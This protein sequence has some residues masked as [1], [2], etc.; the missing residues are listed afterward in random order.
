MLMKISCLIIETWLTHSS[1]H[2]TFEE[3]NNYAK[4]NVFV[5][6]PV[7][8]FVLVIVFVFV[9]VINRGPDLTFLQIFKQFRKCASET[10]HA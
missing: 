7:F 9:F 1:L 6:V 8:V 2:T 10:N 3:D 5:F 4:G